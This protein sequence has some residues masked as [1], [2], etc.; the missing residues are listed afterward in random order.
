[1]NTSTKEKRVTR[2]RQLLWLDNVMFLHLV[3]KYATFYYSKMIKVCEKILLT[4]E[5]FANKKGKVL[6]MKENFLD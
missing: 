2:V 1:M 6:L 5:N 4:G 3:N